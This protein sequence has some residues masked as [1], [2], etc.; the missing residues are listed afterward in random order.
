[1]TGPSQPLERGP[2]GPL[3]LPRGA[4]WHTALGPWA[5]EL[6]SVDRGQCWSVGLEVHQALPGPH[7]LLQASFFP[8][9]IT[10]RSC[11]QIHL[12]SSYRD[13]IK[14]QRATQLWGAMI[15]SCPAW[16][17]ASAIALAW[18]C[19]RHCQGPTSCCRQ[20][21]P[22]HMAPRG[23]AQALPAAPLATS[24]LSSIWLL[25]FQLASC[26]ARS[27]TVLERQPRGAAPTAL[28]P[29][30]DLSLLQKLLQ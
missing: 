30:L 24:L 2:S 6:P 5:R 18:R 7:A 25:G 23:L 21:Q 29:A 14:R 20:A 28:A 4:L 22:L 9:C 17:V 15:E 11:W 12:P 16:T 8:S 10:H 3:N 13:G 1:M 27:G 26:P 19:S